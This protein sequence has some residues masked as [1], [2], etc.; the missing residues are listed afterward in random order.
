MEPESHK[1]PWYVTSIIVKEKIAQAPE[2][3]EPRFSF[4]HQLA[5]T[6]GI[7]G[8]GGGGR[9]ISEPDSQSHPEDC[10]PS[11]MYD[12]REFDKCKD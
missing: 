3:P 7:L 11:A 10:T 6:L 4:S 8:G 1:R 5:I 2:Y 12:P 9:E